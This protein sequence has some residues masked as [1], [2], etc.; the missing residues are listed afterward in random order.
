SIPDLQSDL[1]YILAFNVLIPLVLFYGHY[2]LLIRFPYGRGQTRWRVQHGAELESRLRAVDTQLANLQKD[3]DQCE[4]V[5]KNRGNLQTT[6]D[7][8]IG[9]LFDLIELNGKRDRLNMQRLQILS[10]RQALQDVS[11]SPISLTVASMP[12]RIIQLGIPLVL[13]FKVYEW[14]IV[15]DGLRE[16]ASN[17]NIGVI[18]FFQIVLESTNF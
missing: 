7:D 5:W 1:G 4:F 13:I 10:D 16:V 3:I 12:T 9:M 2:Y 11:E 15:N 8:Q 17:P 14:A 6:K 18:E